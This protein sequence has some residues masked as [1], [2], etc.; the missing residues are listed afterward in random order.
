MCI[1][2]LMHSNPDFKCDGSGSFSGRGG[3]VLTL[4]ILRV[5]MKKQWVSDKRKMFYGEMWGNTV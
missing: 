1:S 2:G 3:Y 4:Q 5:L